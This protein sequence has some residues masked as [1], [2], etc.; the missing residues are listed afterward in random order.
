MTAQLLLPDYV[1]QAK[2]SHG[3]FTDFHELVTGDLFTTLVADAGTS[4]AVSDAA[5]GVVLITTGGTDNNE[6]LVK[7]TKET[8]L[9]A[10]GKPILFEARAKYTEA[11]TDDANIFIGLADAAGAN[12]MV[13]DGAGP[14]TSF[15][16]CGFFK[17]DG[18]TR[19]KV[20]SSLGSTQTITE[21]TAA[22]SLDKLAK[23]AG[24]G[25]YQDFRIDVLPYTSTLEKVCFSIDGVLVATHD[26]TYTSATE[27]QTALYAKAGGSNSEVLYGDW[28]SC[29]QAR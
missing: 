12:L 4:V 21:L 16:G 28:L 29:W 3:F 2:K 6:A 8:F 22:N 19:W 9:F 17:V 14:K 25:S 13:D 5:G 24:G 11:N 23:T 1:R 26:L 7:S 15:S 20:I 27:M 10:D 18:G